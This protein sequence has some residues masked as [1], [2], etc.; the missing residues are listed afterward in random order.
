MR[1]SR[2]K[3]KKRIR[4]LGRRQTRQLESTCLLNLLLCIMV[5]YSITWIFRHVFLFKNTQLSLIIV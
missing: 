1:V 5:A 2:R 4:E 3:K